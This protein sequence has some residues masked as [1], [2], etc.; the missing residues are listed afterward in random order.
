MDIKPIKPGHVLVIPKKHSEYAFDLNDGEYTELL[1][2]AKELAILLK[3]KLGP[4]KIGMAIEGFEVTHVHIHLIPIDGPREMDPNK[5][6]E[7]NNKEL[8]KIA[9]KIKN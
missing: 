3:E 6:K 5:A 8:A 4:K 1:L 7:S 9:E 2:K